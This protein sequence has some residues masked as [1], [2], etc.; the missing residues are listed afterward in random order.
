MDK[1]WFREF[2]DK[3]YED[4]GVM[5]DVELSMINLGIAY[6]CEAQRQKSVT[7]YIPVLSLVELTD[8]FLIDDK[9]DAF[10]SDYFMVLEAHEETYRELCSSTKHTFSGEADAIEQMFLKAEKET[11]RRLVNRWAKTAKEGT[12]LMFRRKL[13]DNITAKAYH[14]VGEDVVLEDTDEFAIVYIARG[15]RD[16]RQAELYDYFPL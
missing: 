16:S 1:K 10:G 5:F 6:A 15:G 12:R 8:K 4:T 14:C 7:P 13:P 3:L 9:L 2:S 11:D